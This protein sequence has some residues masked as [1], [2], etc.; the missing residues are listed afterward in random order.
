MG[1]DRGCLIVAHIF[2]VHF[3]WWA[4]PCWKAGPF[5]SF[6]WVLSFV[7]IRAVDEGEW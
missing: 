3:A 4:D 5:S 7:A 6:S 1:G 2:A